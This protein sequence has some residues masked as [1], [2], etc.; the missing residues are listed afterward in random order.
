LGG[1]SRYNYGEDNTLIPNDKRARLASLRDVAGR[2]GVDLIAAAL[3][4]SLAPDVA[5]ALIVG[6][7]TP[8]HILADHAALRAKIPSAFWDELRSRGILHPD[9]AIPGAGG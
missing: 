3:Q 1:E 5:S 4:F 9:A 2:H 7:A 8:A 6:T